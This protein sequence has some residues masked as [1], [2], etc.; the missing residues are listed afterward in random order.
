MA[1]KHRI[2]YAL[3]RSKIDVDFIQ[4]IED[5]E[6]EELGPGGLMNPDPRAIEKTRE[7]LITD[8]S[9]Q[10]TAQLQE[11]V[12]SLLACSVPYIFLISNKTLVRLLIGY[13]PDG[14]KGINYSKLTI[15][16]LNLLF[17]LFQLA[18]AKSKGD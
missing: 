3:I 7:L 8:I 4:E 12:P 17:F 11:I 5:L 16:E 15:D 13:S 9:E 1:E 10:V 14:T 2:P 18:K 6:P